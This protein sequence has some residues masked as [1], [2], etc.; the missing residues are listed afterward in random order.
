MFSMHRRRLLALC[1]LRLLSAV[2][3]ASAI[4][5]VLVLG[6]DVVALG[7]RLAD[8]VHAEVIGGLG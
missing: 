2:A 4:G 1:N 3:A 8:V 5:P 7:E 6:Q